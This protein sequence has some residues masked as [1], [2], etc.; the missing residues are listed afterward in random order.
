MY[1]SPYKDPWPVETHGLCPECASH[2]DSMYK[3]P[4]QNIYAD[5]GPCLDCCMTIDSMYK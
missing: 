1:K 4:Y 2:S 5:S 3:S